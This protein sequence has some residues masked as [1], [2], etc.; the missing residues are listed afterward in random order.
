MLEEWRGDFFVTLL[1]VGLTF[2][3]GTSISQKKHTMRDIIDQNTLVRVPN[4]SNIP[5]FIKGSRLLSIA[6]G[7]LQSSCFQGLAS[8]ALPYNAPAINMY[9]LWHRKYQNDPQHQWFRQQVKV[10]TQHLRQNR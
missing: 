10:C 7:K 5:M 6:P 3:A 2:T 1:Y 9:M 4:F 8:T